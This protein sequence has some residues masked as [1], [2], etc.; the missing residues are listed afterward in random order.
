MG[1]VINFTPRPLYLWE[2]PWYLGRSQS[3]FGRYGQ[4]KSF[5]PVPGFEPLIIQTICSRY[6]EY[7][8]LLIKFINLKVIY[9]I[10]NLLYALYITFLY[11]QPEEAV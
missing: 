7:D 5:L 6:T 11:L 4:Q 10:Y 9:N 2:I 3:R 8:N 1:W